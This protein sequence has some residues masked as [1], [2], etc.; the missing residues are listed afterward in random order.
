[1]VVVFRVVTFDFGYLLPLCIF[2]PPLA[3]YQVEDFL[4]NFCFKLPILVFDIIL[5]VDGRQ[6]CLLFL[7][8]ERLGVFE[9]EFGSYADNF[10]FYLTKRVP[11]K[12]LTP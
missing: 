7:P 1:M 10:C 12:S 5:V 2:H 4:L 6:F 8:V 9:P 11:F 3:S